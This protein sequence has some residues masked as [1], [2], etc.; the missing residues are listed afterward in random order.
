[1]RFA[2]DANEVWFARVSDPAGQLAP[3]QTIE[4]TIEPP[5]INAF[6]WLARR[7]AD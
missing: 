4:V 6:T 5:P 3:G 7:V 2:T 1:M